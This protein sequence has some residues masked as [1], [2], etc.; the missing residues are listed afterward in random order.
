MTARTIIRIAK[1]TTR[2]GGFNVVICFCDFVFDI[3]TAEMGWVSK[4]SE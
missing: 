4:N 1:D 3:F 2:D